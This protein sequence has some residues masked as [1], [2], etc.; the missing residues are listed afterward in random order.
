MNNELKKLMTP[1]QN[2]YDKLRP[3]YDEEV[4]NA[5]GELIKDPEFAIFIRH[6]M[7]GQD[8]KEV[9]NMLKGITSIEEFQRVFVQPVLDRIIK[10][11]MD[12][13][14]CSGIDRVDKKE[15]YIFI[16]NH[17][18]I[19]LDSSLLNL[20]LFK[21]GYNTTQ[22]AI[23][24]NLL[25]SPMIT[26]LVRINKSFIVKRNIPPRELYEYSKLLS[27]YIAYTL[28]E[29]N[30]SVWI[31]QRE[32]RSKDGSDKTQY[33]LLKML[34]MSHEGEE[35]D[36]FMKM[37]IFPVALS[38][39]YDPCDIFK[40]VE[41][42]LIANSGSFKK[43]KEGDFQSMITGILGYKGRVEISFS[44]PL[45]SNDFDKLNDF[46][47]N[48]FLK[49]LAGIIDN[50]IYCAYKL[51]DTN[52]IAYDLLN[53]TAVFSEKYSEE[54]KEKFID[55]LKEKSDK[56]D[57]VY[58]KRDILNLMLNMYANPIKNKLAENIPV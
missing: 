8:R 13:L 11:S 40:A 12:V 38:Y 47:G 2:E 35:R 48:D 46:H 58:P 26:N 53:G 51:W 9:Y 36:I 55:Y 50:R 49:G 28:S 7:Q 16:T 15:T 22:V 4:N 30:E 31:A 44:S 1:M 20:L 32:G 6:L 5:I 37:N 41:L 17:R 29:R 33:S 56:L 3:Y 18:D 27:S 42:F 45:T 19:V 21:Q 34:A 52:Y 43:T 14:T 39:E 54:S 25:I 24:G 10:N 23:G 57:E